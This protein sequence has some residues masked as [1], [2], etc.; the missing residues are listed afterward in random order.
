ML[1]NLSMFCG[2]ES[3]FGKCKWKNRL[4]QVQCQW[5]I[6]VTVGIHATSIG[7]GVPCDFQTYETVIQDVSSTILTILI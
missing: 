7:V 4:L 3:D 5:E 1:V 2:L 6:G